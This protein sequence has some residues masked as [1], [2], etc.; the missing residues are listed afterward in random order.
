M[1]NAVGSGGAPYP[2]AFG[3]ERVSQRGSHVKVQRATPAGRQSLTVPL[4]NELDRGTLHAVYR[5][6]LR[7]VAEA[8]LRV[9]FQTED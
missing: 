3:F 1:A 2:G 4:H 9:H 6:A 8:E 5:Q 7:F